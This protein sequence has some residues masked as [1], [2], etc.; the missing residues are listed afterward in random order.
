MKAGGKPFSGP[1]PGSRVKLPACAG[2]G[3]LPWPLSQE[4]ISRRVHRFGRRLKSL[5]IP[6]TISGVRDALHSLVYVDLSRKADFAIA[7]R[8]N[9]ICRKEDLGLFEAEFEH[10]WRSQGIPEQ[11]GPKEE[12]G[13][14][15][16]FGSED[17][18]RGEEEVTPVKKRAGVLFSHAEVLAEKDFQV[19]E[20]DDWQEVSRWTAHWIRPLI[21]RCSLR[22]QSSHRGSRLEIRKMFRRSLRVGGDLTALAFRRKKIKPRRLIFLADVSGSMEPYGRFFFLFVQA[23]LNTSFPVEIFAFS[24]RLTYL[25]R[26]LKSKK[27]EEL[28][29]IVSAQ[30]P[31]WSSGTRIG[32]SL[33]QFQRIYGPKLLGA[34]SI[35]LIFSDGWDLGDPALLREAMRRLRRRSYKILWLNPLMGCPDYQPICQGMAA[36]LPWVDRLLPAHNLRALAGVVNT[37]EGLAG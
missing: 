27:M 25:T 11:E 17:P 9:L 34:R 30:V 6:V 8:A 24:T 32:E 28:G 18:G 13:V 22:F 29:E 16:G 19:W 14:R 7:L 2:P 23:W 37:I 33:E 3:P 26:W 1:M 5:G 15:P 31:Q 36:A 21:N 10:F 20:E 12:S 4:C 35:L